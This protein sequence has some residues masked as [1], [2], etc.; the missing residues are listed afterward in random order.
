MWD[1]EKR[2]SKVEVALGELRTGQEA[3]SAK[4]TVEVT[5]IKKM[6]EMLSEN[7]STIGREPPTKEYVHNVN[8]GV[9]DDN[10]I[11]VHDDSNTE[12][13]DGL[14]HHI[15]DVSDDVGNAIWNFIFHDGLDAAETIVEFGKFDATR[16]TMKS[17]GPRQWLSS[18]LINVAACIMPPT[19]MG[20]NET[21]N[22]R[23]YIPTWFAASS[24]NVRKDQA[25]KL[26][27]HPQNKKRAKII[28][29]SLNL[30]DI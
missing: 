2:L 19:D 18:E 10:E 6:L 12:V 30:R 23:W 8:Q 21:Q 29:K 3:L 4:F 20:N 9:C 26:V 17:L 13:V 27:T 22:A 11:E 7:V 24:S 25:L 28:V 5:E 14:V 1:F 16:M 15:T